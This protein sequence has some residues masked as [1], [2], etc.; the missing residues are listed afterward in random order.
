MFIDTGIPGDQRVNTLMSI[1]SQEPMNPE[2][3]AM[4]RELY[5]EPVQADEHIALYND[6]PPGRERL[7]NLSVVAEQDLKVDYYK[8]GE[9]KTFADGTQYRVCSTGWEKVENPTIQNEVNEARVFLDKHILS[10]DVA[11]ANVELAELIKWATINL[12][13]DGVLHI[14]LE[15]GDYDDSCLANLEGSLEVGG[16]DNEKISRIIELLKPLSEEVREMICER[17]TITEDLFDLLYNQA[18]A[19]G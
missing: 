18:S 1:S 11:L 2:V 4:M 15:D 5:G 7:K 9:I 12:N 6:L 17:K 14:L 19:G 3:Q 10:Y 13:N 8:E 16:K